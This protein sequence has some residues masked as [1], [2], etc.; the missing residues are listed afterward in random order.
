MRIVF[1]QILFSLLIGVLGTG[2][3][4]AM[5]LG[6]DELE[7]SNFAVLQGKKVGLVTN[8]SGADST[9]RSAIDTASFNGASSRR[10]SSVTTSPTPWR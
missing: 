1:N 5:T 6:I 4:G 2:A 9:G 10:I 7:K 8:P 3:C